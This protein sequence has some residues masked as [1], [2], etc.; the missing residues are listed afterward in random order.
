MD[1]VDS[2]A[3]NMVDENSSEVT[4][5]SS[6]FALLIFDD[7]NERYYFEKWINEQGQELFKKYM[8]EG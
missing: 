8:E 2:I 4:L 5:R 1:I 6:R 7:S 3:K